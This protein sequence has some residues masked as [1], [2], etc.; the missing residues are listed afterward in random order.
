VPFVEIP[1]HG[2]T[3]RIEHEWLGDAPAGAP[4]GMPGVPCARRVRL[5]PA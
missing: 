1:R 3:V 2:R 5:L 4:L